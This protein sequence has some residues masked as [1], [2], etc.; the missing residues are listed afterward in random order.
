ML[1]PKHLLP[2]LLLAA[3]LLAQ[4]PTSQPATTQPT[5]TVKVSTAAELL[6]AIAPD[7]TIELAEG[8]Y[9]LSEVP[10]E[11]RQYLRWTQ[12]FDGNTITIRN[13]KNLRLVCTG[14]PPA[15][16]IATPRYANVLAFDHCENVSLEN[17]VLGHSPDKGEC[18][19][20]VI[21][22][23]DSKNISLT[24]CDLYG[25]G[26]EALTL[27][28]SSNITITDSTL[29]DC[30]YGIMTITSSDHVT[31]TR[32]TLRDNQEFWGIKLDDAD[33]ITFDTCTLSH[34]KST[35]EPLIAAISSSAI[36]FKNCTLKDNTA[37]ALT[38]KPDTVKL[39]SC[40]TTNNT[41]T[42]KPRDE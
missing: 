39:E 23:S 17:L 2:L 8:D 25:C 4:S 30:S 19:N 3:P 5:H 7:T 26:T 32:T 20:G 24:K 14:N 40:T 9:H 16:L 12:E 28:K 37:T 27:T 33:H 34:N 36:L 31:L 1:S 29:R 21:A 38:N 11:K 13:C 6:A 35:E 15:H 10:D 18:S 22:T 42:P 41:F